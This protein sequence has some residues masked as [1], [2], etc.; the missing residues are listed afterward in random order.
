MRVAKPRDRKSRNLFR[1]AIRQY[2]RAHS[3]PCQGLYD[4]SVRNNT[5]PRRAL[6][7]K[8]QNVKII[9][10]GMNLRIS[11][12]INRGYLVDRYNLI[13]ENKPPRIDKGL[14]ARVFDKE[15]CVKI[16]GYPHRASIA[17]NFFN[18]Y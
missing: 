14:L 3:C 16:F 11:D 17:Y 9:M 12:N 8:F 18:Q 2:L 5:N 15:A 10:I 1:F 13:D 6:C 4:L 7:Q